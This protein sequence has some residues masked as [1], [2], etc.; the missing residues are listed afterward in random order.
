MPMTPDQVEL[1]IDVLI[2]NADFQG[3]KNIKDR[4]K[5]E[6]E[7]LKKSLSDQDFT[8]DGIEAAFTNI[9]DKGKPG[10]FGAH[11]ASSA[12]LAVGVY[13]DFNKKKPTLSGSLEN[14]LIA[15]SSNPSKALPS[16][17]DIY[18]EPSVDGPLDNK[19]SDVEFFLDS[20]KKQIKE[21]KASRDTINTALT[22]LSKEPS[23]SVEA[24]AEE[25]V[26]LYIA[27]ALKGIVDSNI[28]E[29]LDDSVH[30]DDL[31][32]ALKAKLYALDLEDAKKA[33]EESKDAKIVEYL[34]SLKNSFDNS[35][36]RQIYEAKSIAWT[37]VDQKI[38]KK[39]AE[40]RYNKIIKEY[41]DFFNI[42]EVKVIPK[43]KDLFE[44]S[45]GKEL[46]AA[47]LYQIAANGRK[48][49]ATK[50]LALRGVLRAG[51]EASIKI[52]FREVFPF[53][54]EELI[55]RSGLL[56]NDNSD[57]IKELRGQEKYARFFAQDELKDFEKLKK[58]FDSKEG[59]AVRGKFIAFL[60]E[61]KNEPPTVEV[62]KTLASDIAKAANDEAVQGLLAGTFKGSPT[63]TTAE[64]KDAGVTVAEKLP[65]LQAE[66]KKIHAKNSYENFLKR[67]DIVAMPEVLK[68]FNN[69]DIKNDLI[70]YF[71]TNLVP[72]PAAI[73]TLITAIKDLNETGDA[74]ARDAGAREAFMNAFPG[75]GDDFDTHLR[76][77]GLVNHNPQ[78]QS[79]IADALAQTNAL[80]KFDDFIKRPDVVAVPSVV[81][82]LNLH[83]I[84]LVSQ[85]KSDKNLPTNEEF[86]N[87][88]IRI[89][90]AETTVLM[91]N[92]ITA[93][94]YLDDTQLDAANIVAD[95]E[96][97]T[98][99]RA[100]A[101]YQT[102]FNQDYVKDITSLKEM[103]DG[104]LELKDSLILRLGALDNIL[105]NELKIKNFIN[106]IGTATTD[107]EVITA[108]SKLF[109]LKIV[110]G[111][112][113]IMVKLE[114][115]EFKVATASTTYL[116]D[117]LVYAHKERGK[118]QYNSFIAAITAGSPYVAGDKLKSLFSKGD[119][120]T[121]LSEYWED[122][123]RS[124]P[125]D[126][127]FKSFRENVSLI[128]DLTKMNGAFEPWFGSNFISD[129]KLSS[130]EK[131]ELLG[132]VR[133][134]TVMEIP[135]LKAL[136]PLK[137]KLE[138]KTNAEKLK[139]LWEVPGKKIP[140]ATKIKKLVT[141]LSTLSADAK[142]AE[143]LLKAAVAT[144]FDSGTDLDGLASELA[145]SAPDLRGQAQ[146]LSFIKMAEAE[147]KTD[148]PHLLALFE[149][150]DLKDL[151]ITHWKDPANSSPI[152]IDSLLKG[153]ADT[154]NATPRNI[155]D[156]FKTYLGIEVPVVGASGDNVLT[157]NGTSLARA[158]VRFHQFIKLD[159]VKAMPSI[160]DLLKTPTIKGNL[161]TKWGDA[162]KPTPT[163]AQIDEF[164][165]G[166]KALNSADADYLDQAQRLFINK[167]GLTD[168]ITP[169]QVKA[170]GFN[171]KF[172]YSLRADFIVSALVEDSYLKSLLSNSTN[173]EKIKKHLE[174][175][176]G[177][178]ADESALIL[179]LATTRTKS[180]V[181]SAMTALGLDTSNPEE[182]KKILAD[183]KKR[184]LDFIQKVTYADVVKNTAGKNIYSRAH[185]INHNLHVERYNGKERTTDQ[186]RYQN[187]FD[188]V[189]ESLVKDVKTS[190]ISTLEKH[191]DSLHQ[192]IADL[193]MAAKIQEAILK[194]IQETTATEG[195]TDYSLVNSPAGDGPDRVFQLQLDKQYEASKARV[196]SW[197]SS[198]TSSYEQ[199]LVKADM[200]R[201][202][203][204]KLD[205]INGYITRAQ[206]LQQQVENELEKRVSGA[207]ENFKRYTQGDMTVTQ[208]LGGSSIAKEDLDDNILDIIKGTD[209]APA[210]S[211]GSASVGSHN[212]TISKRSDTT[213]LFKIETTIERTGA[214]TEYK[215]PDRSMGAAPG[216]T[217][218]VTAPREGTF[219]S[220]ATKRT[221]DDT[222]QSARVDFYISPEDLKEFE[223]EAK[224]AEWLGPPPKRIMQWAAENIELLL[225]P[226][227]RS[228][229]A[230]K[231]NVR[232]ANAG[233]PSY[234]MDALVIYCEYLKQRD[235]NFNY[236]T[237]PNRWTKPK[238]FDTRV[239]KF[240]TMW[241]SSAS[242]R[243]GSNKA[244]DEERES[245]IIYGGPK[246]K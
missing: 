144:A 121:S 17:N 182:N 107:D 32:E 84:F 129:A 220:T 126:N 155:R 105:P 135:E 159:E 53:L 223:K 227:D 63:I 125:S 124:F 147:L 207:S 60:G 40:E 100:Q 197:G 24:D 167:F 235:N 25:D 213:A 97:V 165:Q 179:K 103:F 87:F 113:P 7:I 101:R 12:L 178:D 41:D 190:S 229:G 116:A 191:D 193:Q 136:E 234:M 36:L 49:E 232:L 96:R 148:L 214:P 175:K 200:E 102:F 218:D 108:L 164:K 150:P 95:N 115:A 201:H 5:D 29:N 57:A 11:N 244:K 92:Q 42:D 189:Q 10:A 146:Y 31:K 217:V 62:M 50:M 184:E 215:K 13:T 196:I 81:E 18:I 233:L 93:K 181:V 76:T 43:I 162:T 19:D 111:S 65:A 140:D 186:D 79:L 222:K 77:A 75:L 6:W 183:N 61:M 231:P 78:L 112:P 82:F 83:K 199:G 109:T 209:A 224:T 236:T 67:D 64:F 143:S 66:A 2:T 89:S 171:K 28:L 128:D 134:E 187:F 74:G 237:P 118:K 80:K 127:E 1:I 138:G 195:T 58:L 91:R 114:E 169:G 198:G 130:V 149:K 117:L 54:T 139:K 39:A 202:A 204:K 245:G 4:K 141:D 123:G 137:T 94:F 20:A 230:P 241:E 48:P 151:L 210:S 174:T 45:A 55:T 104:K 71:E 228:P 161:T 99:L 120:K 52:A 26:S 163:P 110:P 145:A 168:G 157:D 240:T 246:K 9:P 51:T 34:E 119:A 56:N 166:I 70:K 69:A 14:Y 35:M 242:F 156:V 68:I 33:I 194:T 170:A 122:P 158:D 172:L 225:E 154:R 152:E 38:L 46:K 73:D 226:I 216:S 131:Q 212:L 23:D 30:K 211:R 238:F 176:D 59:D 3:L 219:V 106:N 206:Y 21:S 205:K 160:E 188:Q 44:K 239:E 185:V 203:Q 86:A 133:Y 85:V 8:L 132:E 72:N 27:T 16:S 47:F 243:L 142:E 15:R 22:E 180:G 37:E 153:L 98:N 221:H 90:E 173:R 88:L 177:P 208:V 192:A